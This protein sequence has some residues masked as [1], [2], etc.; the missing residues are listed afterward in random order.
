MHFSLDG[1]EMKPLDVL[2][3]KLVE[4]A[5]SVLSRATG[6]CTLILAPATPTSGEAY[7]NSKKSKF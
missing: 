2:K 1:K 5:L 4:L 6:K 3:E 7:Y